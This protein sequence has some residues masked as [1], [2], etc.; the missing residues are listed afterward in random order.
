MRAR[1]ADGGFDALMIDGANKQAV[2]EMR[3]RHEIPWKPR[4]RPARATS[5]S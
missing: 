2:E 5:S 1:E 4:T 3:K